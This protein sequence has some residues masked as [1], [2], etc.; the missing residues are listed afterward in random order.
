MGELK[1]VMT[2]L[3]TKTPA[4]K[5]KTTEEHI[6]DYVKGSIKTEEEI[7]LL[8]EHLRDFKKSFVENTYLT[9]AQVK[10]LEKAKKLIKDNADID[11][12]V[13]MVGKIKGTKV[14]ISEE[15]SEE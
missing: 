9:K 11:K 7:K 15:S 6:A 3:G 10:L 8:R 4:Q 2:G 12:L 13:D 1:E 14:S 5:M